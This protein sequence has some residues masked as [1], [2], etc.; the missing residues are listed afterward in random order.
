MK[1][2][3]NKKFKNCDISI[4]IEDEFL[5]ELTLAKSLPTSKEYSELALDIFTQLEEYFEGRRTE[6]KVKTKIQYSYKNQELFTQILKEIPYSQK[7]T[8][9]QMAQKLGNKN[10]SRNIGFLCGKNPILIIIP[11][12][13]IVDTNGIGGYSAGVNIKPHLLELE[14]RS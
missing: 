11:C 10:L 8:Y 7:L 9:S 2:T 6:F 1:K 13:R 12:H 3:Y 4:T 14:A 5:T